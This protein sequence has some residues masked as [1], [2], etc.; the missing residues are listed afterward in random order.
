MLTINLPEP[1]E[2]ATQHAIKK[3]FRAAG[4]QVYST[5]QVRRSMVA[6][7][8]PDLWVFVPR[9]KCAFWF[10]V[11]R[12]GGKLRKEQSEFQQR[13]AAAGVPYFWG[14]MDEAV[15]VLRTLD[16]VA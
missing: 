16:L 10:E 6:L 8:L 4:C 9:R 3:L 12:P 7:G 14:A 1:T 15:R 2:K 11:K 13:C 5:S